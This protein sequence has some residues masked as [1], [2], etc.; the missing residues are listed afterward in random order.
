MTDPSHISVARSGDITHPAMLVAMGSSGILDHKWTYDVRPEG[1][2]ILTWDPPTCL[3]GYK[4]C[5]LTDIEWTAGA[6]YNTQSTWWG[7]VRQ[8]HAERER[9]KGR[10]ICQIQQKRPLRANLA[11]KEN[12]TKKQ[13][14]GIADTLRERS[15]RLATENQSPRNL[16]QETEFELNG[17]DRTIKNLETERRS[18]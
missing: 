5:S 10:P 2:K 1:S 16:A 9:S 17:A 3:G 4:S 18:R 6:R 14:N 15:D 11:S 13:G 8:V 12:T 7:E